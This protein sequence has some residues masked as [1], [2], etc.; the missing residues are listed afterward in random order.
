MTDQVMLQAVQEKLAE[1][2]KH[3]NRM[4]TAA[5][6]LSHRFPL[7]VESFGTLDEVDSSFIDQ[8]VY[9]FSKLQDTL[10]E[11]VFSGILKLGREE[12]KGRTFLD[13]LHRME[14]L[15]IVDSDTW[16]SLRELRNEIAHEYSNEV[17]KTVL[18]LNIVFGKLSLLADIRRRAAAFVAERF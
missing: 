13:V 11:K 12:V 16:L 17:D 4:L 3:E 2:E 14:E 9:R 1:C 15:Q 18:A 8:M 5:E 6:R 10:G 7:T